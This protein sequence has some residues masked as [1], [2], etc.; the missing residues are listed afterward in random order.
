[1]REHLDLT[2]LW[3]CQPAP[4]DEGEEEGYCALDYDAT[5]WRE[6]AVP[7][8]FDQVAPGMESYEGTC[9]YRRW[10]EVPADWRGKRVAVR[11]EG[12]NYHAQVWLNGHCVGRH[13]DGFL[14][15]EFPI[16][17]QLRWGELN[18]IAVRVDNV[19]RRGEVPGI[20]RGWRPCGGIL[21]EVELSATDPL[22]IESTYVTAEPGEGGGTVQVEARLVNER[23]R[24][25][26][27]LLT[28]RVEDG[29]AGLLA[30]AASGR[31]A[32]EPGADRRVRLTARAEG[33]RPWSPDDPALYVAKL[34]LS[35][36]G[37]VV[38]ALDV[39][40]GFRRIEARQ[41]GLFLNGE[42]IFLTGFN[43]HEDSPRTGMC[44]D[45]ETARRDLVQMKETGAN[46][47]RLC[48]Y[49]HHPRELDLCDEL[50]LVAMC[51]IPLYWWKGAEE[52]EENCA[53]KLQAARRQMAGLIE[54]DRNH[55]SVIFWSVSNENSEQRPE[56]VAGNSELLR[57]VREL[58]PTRLAV[59]V[60][61]HWTRHPHFELDDVVCVNGY[62]SQG[63]SIR[64]CP[65]RLD[66]AAAFWRAELTKLRGLYPGK[67]ILI[68]EFGYPCL[69]GVLGGTLGEDVQARVIEAE[70]RGMDVDGVC[71]MT[72]WCWADHPWPEEPFI[73]Y[74]TTSPFGVL[75][76]RRKKLPGYAAVRKLY[77]KKQGLVR[78]GAQA[79][80]AELEGM[81][82]IMIRPHLRD[83]PQAE[84]PPGFSIRAMRPGEAGVWTDI[85]RDAEPYLTVGDDLFYQEFGSDLPATL[86][87]CFFIVNEKGV[88]VATISAWYSRDFKGQDW[89]RVHWVATRPAYRRRGLAKAGLSYTLNRL[90]EWHE[91]ACLDTSTRRIP[92]IKMY[93][94]FG[95]VPDL[96]QPNAR[97]AWRQVREA[98]DHP[99]LEGL[100]L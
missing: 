86:R 56:V 71:G 47:V 43:R 62:P 90:A 42:P 35:C 76:R 64:G 100:D 19:R 28:M 46:F 14:R 94:D 55:P 16:G 60:S 18:L 7:S 75:T 33:V 57:L 83:I 73:C 91:R 21:R 77:R 92:A 15:F 50:G 72:L 36:D 32:L 8:S 10:F 2:G 38:D 63:S 58:D 82:L 79:A 41:A 11:F 30:E 23:P 59:H 45:L 26:E 40:L 54:R 53:R 6:V 85:E 27:A 89:G 65:E 98:L 52:G 37:A 61:D 25:A 70:A 4:Y 81:P 96:D 29:P 12:V 66:E 3:R 48:H 31:I 44:T 49:P 97:E 22:R 95:F 93:L 20:E 51:E 87:R 68:T 24:R 34:G 84:L 9:W 74:M 99:A 5:R 67:P 78:G 13:P 69:E 80:E 39:R 17:G 88:A 1:M